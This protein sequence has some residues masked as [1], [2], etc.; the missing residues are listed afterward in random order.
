MAENDT[1]TSAATP[2]ALVEDLYV[3]TPDGVN[4]AITLF[5]PA[6][7][8]SNGIAAQINSSMAPPR[9]YYRAFSS[10]LAARGFPVLAYDYRGIGGSIFEFPPPGVRTAVDWARIDQTVVADYLAQRFP[11]LAPVL[12]GHSFGGQ[13]LGMTRHAPRWLAVL[14]VGTSHGYYAKWP[15]KRRWKMWLRSFIMAPLLRLAPRKLQQRLEDRMGIP[16]PLGYEMSIYLRT[17]Y[18]FTD[19]NG[20]P[21]RPHND[22]LRAPVRHIIFSDDEVVLPGSDID[23]EFFYPNAKKIR[24]LKTPADYGAERVGH[25]G[26]FRRSMPVMAWADAGDWLEQQVAA[27]A[28]KPRNN[29]R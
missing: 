20:R 9:Q 26:F 19:R 8:R 5:H 4:I 7:G 25:F 11:E 23:I 14:L 12:V 21:I 17:P 3:P 22:E 1:K 24:D 18:F 16:F 2:S 27:L 10:Y 29:L 15:A 13:I 6:A 28:A